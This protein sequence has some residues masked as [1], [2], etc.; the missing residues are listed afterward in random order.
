M[1]FRHMK[2]PKDVRSLVGAALLALGGLFAVLNQCSDHQTRQRA[3][4]S[5]DPAPAPPADM[6]ERP[7]GR[8]TWPRLSEGIDEQQAE[9]YLGFALSYNAKHRQANW[10][11]YELTRDKLMNNRTERTNNFDQDRGSGYDKGHLAPSADMRWDVQAQN[12]CFY[13]TNMSPQVNKFNTGI[14]ERLESQVRKWAKEKKRVQ[15]VTGPVL[16]NLRSTKRIGKNKDISVPREYYKVILFQESG[17][18]EG[19]GFIMK[20]D[21]STPVLNRSAVSIDEVEQKTGID[22]FA[23]LPD[24]LETVAEKK[25]NLSFW[26]AE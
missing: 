18:I 1:F 22:F 16:Y 25:V 15:V 24:D 8:Q 19:I 5:V 13:M 21:E 4:V 2:L 7:A 14:W 26:F 12:E 23:H 3:D 20:N 11:A 10:V 9:Q 6:A 17:K